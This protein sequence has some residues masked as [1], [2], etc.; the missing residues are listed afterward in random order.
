MYGKTIGNR[1]DVRQVNNKKD[2]L[3]W[4]SKPNYVSQ[5]ILD[6]DLVAIHKI[7]SSL[8]LNKPAYVRIWIL[9]LNKVPK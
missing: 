8:A 4:A 7:K 1:V 3:K 6:N 9:E 5:K 2:S